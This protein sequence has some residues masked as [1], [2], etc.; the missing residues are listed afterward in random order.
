[1]ARRERLSGRLLRWDARR[2]CGP[3]S[4]AADPGD[5]PTLTGLMAARRG[6]IG[7]F[8]LVR[9][10]VLAAGVLIGYW[11]FSSY[12]LWVA[13]TLLVIVRPDPGQ[14]V[15][16]AVPRLVGTA[17]GI[18]VADLL[19]AAVDSEG[20]RIVAFAG[21]AFGTVLFYSANYFL[22]VASLSAFLVLAIEVAGGDPKF[23]GGQRLLATVAGGIMGIAVVWLWSIAR[24]PDRE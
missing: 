17:A 21:A 7:Q 5:D 12:P 11:W 15:D 4:T 16:V 14:T 3:A 6:P 9:A 23:G 19:L 2:T 24:A 20:A 1:M 10:A 22:F 13:I 18:A 8:A